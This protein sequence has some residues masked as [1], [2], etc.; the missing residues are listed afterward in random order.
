MSDMHDRSLIFHHSLGF[1]QIVVFVDVLFTPLLLHLNTIYNQMYCA[2]LKQTSHF[3]TKV[4]MFAPNV[5]YKWLIM[6]DLKNNGV[7]QLACNMN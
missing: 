3:G 5:S 1:C 2:R 6:P 4:T 7:A